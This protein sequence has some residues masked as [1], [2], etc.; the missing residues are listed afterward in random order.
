MLLART[1][2]SERPGLQGRT[3]N[4][5]SL[6][7][8]R[9]IRNQAPDAENPPLR[10]CPS[11]RMQ[12]LVKEFSLPYSNGAYIEDVAGSPEWQR[13]FGPCQPRNPYKFKLKEKARVHVL[14]EPEAKGN[15]VQHPWR[16]AAPAPTILFHSLSQEK[17]QF[18]WMEEKSRSRWG[19]APGAR[20]SLGGRAVRS[21]FS[22][23]TRV[24]RL[25][26]SGPDA[27]EVA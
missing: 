19:T 23:A 11:C 17:S 21:S 13:L 26:E 1:A 9:R 12:Y 15:R 8:I 24:A 27:R 14:D 6:L 4:T 18:T 25:A 10:E 7:G 16:A 20:C 3:R 22:L 5:I 2:K